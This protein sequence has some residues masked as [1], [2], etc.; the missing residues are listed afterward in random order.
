MQDKI[1]RVFIDTEFT[2]LHKGNTLISIGLISEDCRNVFYA[3]ITDYDESQCDE[4]IQKHVIEKL[5]F[6]DKKPF[7][8][9][10]PDGVVTYEIKGTKAEVSAFLINWL[11]IFKEIEFWGDCVADDW[12]LFIDLIGMGKPMRKMPKN[13]TS[14]QAFDIF[15]VLKLKGYNPKEHRHVLLGLTDGENQHNALYDADITRQVYN[16]IMT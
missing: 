13:F 10:K 7:S 1:T 14:Y 16:K 9:I 4:W 2:G 6:R 8:G 5:R 15:T 12:L 11:K 3:E